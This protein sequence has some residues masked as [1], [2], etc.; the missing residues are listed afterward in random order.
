MQVRVHR[1]SHARQHVAQTR[2]IGD[3]ETRGLR[4]LVPLTDAALAVAG[5]VLLE[6]IVGVQ[7][8]AVLAE[9]LLRMIETLDR[10]LRGLRD[11]GLRGV[12]LVISDAHAGLK[13]SIA[14]VF[15]GASWQRCKVHLMRNLLGTVPAASKDMVA[16]TVRTIFAQPDAATTR[17]A[18]R[19]ARPARPRDNRPSSQIGAVCARSVTT[20]KRFSPFSG[21]IGCCRPDPA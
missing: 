11:R 21:H 16:A 18:G 3:V 13:A 5:N 10:D 17:L 4:Q 19:A 1:E 8:E 14:R 12:R 9:D 2:D 20:L 15:T 7:K 6:G